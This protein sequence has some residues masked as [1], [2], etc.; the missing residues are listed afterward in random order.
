ME[1]EYFNWFCINEENMNI[2]CLMFS[3]SFVSTLAA[4]L[5]GCCAHVATLHARTGGHSCWGRLHWSACGDGRQ[6]DQ[7][8]VHVYA[9][10]S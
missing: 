7:H 9:P 2:V 8:R 6:G 10:V 4:P 1:R 5:H 3:G